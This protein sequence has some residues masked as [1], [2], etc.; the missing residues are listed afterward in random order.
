VDYLIESLL[1]PSAK[2]KEGYHMVVVNT[3]GGQVFSGGLVKDGDTELV[4]RDPSNNLQSVPKAEVASQIMSPVSMMPAGLTA[5]LREDEFVDLVAFLSALG[6]EGD[7]KISPRKFVRNWRALGEMEPQLVDQ[8][9][10]LGLPFLHDSSMNLPW[11]PLNSLV[12]G[13]IPLAEIP[14]AQRMYP[15]HPRVVRMVL[16]AAEAGEV[17]LGLSATEGIVMVVGD[18][19]LQEVASTQ[20]IRVAQG[21]TSVTILITRAA[22]DLSGFSLELLSGAVEVLP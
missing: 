3:K 17:E 16:K 13:E 20:K 21:E 5:S 9:R 6:Q 18:Q 7:Y 10:H 14:A 15:W 11:V 1:D 4:I 22:G 2:I 8:V 19:I 12:S